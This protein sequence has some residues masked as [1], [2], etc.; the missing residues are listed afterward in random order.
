MPTQAKR[1]LETLMGRQSH[2]TVRDTLE[3]SASIDLVHKLRERNTALKAR[4]LA[5]LFGVTQQHIYKLAAKGVIPS[6]RVGTAVRFDPSVVA[7]W[8]KRKGM[9]VG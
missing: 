9:S 3:S 1:T 5:Q 2:K 8:L 7:D 4:D 6:F